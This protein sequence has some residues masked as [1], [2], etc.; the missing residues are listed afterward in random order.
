MSIA[1][2]NTIAPGRLAR[3]VAEVLFDALRKLKRLGEDGC[4]S[5]RSELFARRVVLTLLGGVRV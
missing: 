3:P 4:G 1:T 5:D 2:L